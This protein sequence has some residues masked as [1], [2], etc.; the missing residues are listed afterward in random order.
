V[1]TQ[2]ASSPI[3]DMGS[4]GEESALQAVASQEHRV[5]SSHGVD[6]SLTVLHPFASVWMNALRVG[7]EPVACRQTC[8]LR[9]QLSNLDRMIGSSKFRMATDAASPLRKLLPCASGCGVCV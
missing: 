6:V 3:S 4:G 5:S 1:E 9:L 2:I 8:F 7:D